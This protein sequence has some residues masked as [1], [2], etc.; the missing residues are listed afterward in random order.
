MPKNGK[1]VKIKFLNFS[2]MTRKDKDFK[3]AVGLYDSNSETIY[4]EKRLPIHNPGTRRLAL[5]HELVHSRL[6]KGLSFNGL[7]PYVEI[8]AICRTPFDYLTTAE[9][10]IKKKITDGGKLTM[11]KNLKKIVENIFYFLRILPDKE[12]VD[13]I[14]KGR[15]KNG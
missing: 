9:C 10:L 13:L 14:V 8:E 1:K 5:Q 15:S 12:L 2:T 11:K 7:E 6:E 3:N 4:I